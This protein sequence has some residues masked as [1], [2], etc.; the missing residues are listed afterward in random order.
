MIKREFI[1]VTNDIKIRESDSSIT[2]FQNLH[3]RFSFFN[4]LYLFRK[5][6]IKD[7]GFKKMSIYNIYKVTKIYYKNSLLKG[8]RIFIETFDNSYT[9][10]FSDKNTL[11][12]NINNLKNT[13]LSKYIID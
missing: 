12:K 7:K 9:L 8:S 5:L 13:E 6:N 11:V 1:Y 4:L 2:L 10:I 3:L